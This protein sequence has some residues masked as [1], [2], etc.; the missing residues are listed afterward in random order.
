MAS[1]FQRRGSACISAALMLMMAF[2]AIAPARA[3][4]PEYQPLTQTTPSSGQSVSAQ[5]W[6]PADPPAPL[7]SDGPGFWAPVIAWVMA[8]KTAVGEL[9]SHVWKGANGTGT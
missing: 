6:F 2:G 5:D 7:S 4:P 1:G 3:H 9:I 8:W